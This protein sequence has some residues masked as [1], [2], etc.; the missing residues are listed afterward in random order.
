MGG[1]C[2]TGDRCVWAVMVAGRVGLRGRSTC[3]YRREMRRKS[4]LQGPYIRKTKK[5]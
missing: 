1:K 5:L 3:R 4:H 2:T